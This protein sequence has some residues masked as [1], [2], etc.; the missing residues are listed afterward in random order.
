MP[1]ALIILSTADR[2]RIV[3]KYLASLND[4][5]LLLVCKLF[6]LGRSDADVCQILKIDSLELTLIKR[7]I[8]NGILAIMKGN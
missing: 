3:H 1:T 6:S 2:K 7:V 4:K 5:R 8:A